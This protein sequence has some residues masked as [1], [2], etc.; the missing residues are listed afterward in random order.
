MPRNLSTAAAIDIQVLKYNAD[1]ETLTGVGVDMTDYDSV[2]FI[3]GMQSGTAESATI[4]M[5]AQQ[6]GSSGYGD[7]ADLEG[8]SVSA[9]KGTATTAHALAILEVVGPQ[10]QYV[11]P[12]IAVPNVATA[13]AVFC[14]ALRFGPQ[15]LPVSNSGTNTGV[16]I[17]VSPAEGTA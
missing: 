13:T 15:S 4:T 5:K 6:A 7:A 10:E 14:I 12:V 9:V 1:N 17:H 16:E 2:V 3:A 8:T 11:R